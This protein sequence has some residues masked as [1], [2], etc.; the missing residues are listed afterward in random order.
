MPE[1]D[2]MAETIATLP[3]NALGREAARLMEQTP[4]AK[5]PDLMKAIR[6][7][8]NE[9]AAKLQAAAEVNK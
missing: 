7:M 3:F 9:T 4:V 5:R 8:C 1:G 6:E 2:I